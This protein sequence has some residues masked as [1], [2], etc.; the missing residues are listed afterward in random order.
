MSVTGHAHSGAL[1]FKPALAFSRE[2]NSGDG[3]ARAA[4]QL[5]VAL[6]D[7]AAYGERTQLPGAAASANGLPSPVLGVSRDWSDQE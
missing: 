1:V 7:M 3:S 5:A 4:S 2:R 6:L